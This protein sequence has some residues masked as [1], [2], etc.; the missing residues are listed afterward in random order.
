MS[1][2][3]LLY[4]SMSKIALAVIL[5]RSTVKFAD[6]P[7]ASI[8]AAIEPPTNGIEDAALEAADVA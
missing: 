2:R 1:A 6:I 8:P 4:S 5:A 3:S 7:T